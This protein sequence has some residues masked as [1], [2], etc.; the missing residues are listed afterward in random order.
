MLIRYI[1]DHTATSIRRNQY[2]QVQYAKYALPSPKV[3]DLLLPNNY[4]VRAYYLRNELNE[5]ESVYLYQNEVFLCRCDKIIEYNTAN[6]EWLDDDAASYTNQS[7]Y[8]AQFNKLVKDSKADLGK[9][10]I[11]NKTDYHQNTPANVVTPH[12]TAPAAGLQPNY[13]FEDTDT[14]EFNR[15][16]AINSL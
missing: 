5:I 14:S 9:I 3:L 2:V 12:T 11:I 1:G 16:N 13:N 8:V 7:K 4:E 15:L 6:A 10:K